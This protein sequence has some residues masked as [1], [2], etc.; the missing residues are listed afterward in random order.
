MQQEIK[1]IIE[2]KNKISSFLE[3]GV[4]VSRDF[5]D[6][7]SD[8]QLKETDTKE[9][10]FIDEDVI[11]L[12]KNKKRPEIDW[13]EFEK[14]KVLFEKEKDLKT[15][16]KFLEYV[17]ETV[18][19]KEEDKTM[20]I[21]KKVVV[22]TIFSYK[23][24]PKKKELGDFVSFF[25]ARFRDLKNILRNR[26]E[27]QNITSINRILEKKDRENISLIGIVKNK[28][29]TKNNNV[30]LV[31]EDLTGEISVLINKNKP[32]IYNQA[33]DIVLDEVIGVNGVN[34]DNIVF[35]NN[36]VWPD[37]AIDKKLKKTPDE[38]Y[39]IFL[40]DLHVGSIN[41]LENKFEK[42]LKWINSETGTEKQ[43]K[44]AKKVKYIFVLGD[45]VDGVGVYPN[46]EHELIIQDLYKQ[47]EK[48]AELLQKIPPD[49]KIIICP[50]NHDAMRLAEPQLPIYKDFSS[51]IWALSNV[52]MVSNPSMVNIHSSKSFPGINVLLYHGSSFDYF[53]ANVDSLR[54]EGGYDRA[55]LIMKFLL[56]RRHLAPP[57]SST[58][59]IPDEE[60]DPLVIKDVPDIFAS[61]HIHKTSMSNYRN[62]SLICGS[63]WQSKTSFQEKLGHH[64]EPARV[65]IV[66][67]QTREMRVLRF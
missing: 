24:E 25:N 53:V 23:K 44:I 32:E 56:K 3:K 55:D 20:E 64:P 10:L 46:Q 35:A 54:S 52:L 21:K 62:I 58:Q 19:S 59:H 57:H 17:D 37:V 6:N 5:L 4:L 11:R 31:L 33:I 7:T 61:G 2:K 42:F 40:S 27:F 47:Y 22:K 66:N 28:Q 36:I 34:G 8:F 65:P 30:F 15:Y 43:K 14:S 63:C 51:L 39:T 50:G 41:F 45:I 26:Q 13:I 29:L 9:I 49:K 12:L 16:K 60:R 18:I 67:L 1:E 38:V 48:C